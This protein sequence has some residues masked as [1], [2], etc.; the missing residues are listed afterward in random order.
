MLIY[1][2]MIAGAAERAK[3]RVPADVDNYK[4]DE[5]PHFHF[6][7]C[8]QLSKR[9]TPGAHWENANII[10]AIPEDELRTVTFQQLLDKGY[11]E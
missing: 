7:C 3:M 4:P 10:A 11:V 6:F 9:M 5:F 8:A 2:S 1:P